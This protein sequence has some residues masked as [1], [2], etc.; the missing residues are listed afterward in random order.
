M[1]CFFFFQAED[2]IRDYKVTGVQTCALPIT[3][4]R[5]PKYSEQPRL[6]IGPRRELVL[7]F[8]RARIRLL[9]EILGVGLVPGEMPREVVQ[10]VD[11]RQRVVRYGTQRRATLLITGPA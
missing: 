6:E 11:I 7:S 2:G 1:I 10:C 8:D 9:H 4:E 5:V 3:H